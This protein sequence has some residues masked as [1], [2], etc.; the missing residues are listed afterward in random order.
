[1][2]K[3]MK[4]R[5]PFSAAAIAEKINGLSTSGGNRSNTGKPVTAARVRY[6]L[7]NPERGNNR[8]RLTAALLGMGLTNEGAEMFI[9]AKQ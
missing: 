4:K 3:T 2:N 8:A 6:M 9:G 1:M 5:N 7:R